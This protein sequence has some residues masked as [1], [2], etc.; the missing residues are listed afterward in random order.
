MY[1][2][3]DIPLINYGIVPGRV[4]GE[5][6]AVKGIFDLPKRIGETHHEW[7]ESDGVQPFVDAD[8]LFFNGR[9]ILFQGIIVG[10]RPTLKTLLNAFKNAVNAFTDVVPFETPYGTYC[11]LVNSVTPKFYNGGAVVIIE[12]TEPV[13]GATCSIG[14]TPT[15]YSSA[16][17][18][19]SATKNNCQSGYYGSSVTLTAT[20]GKFTSTISQTA[21]DLL[22]I[23]WVRDYKQDYANGSG[24]CIVN[25]PVW[26]N[27]KVSGV[28][29]KDDCGA[30][31]IGSEVSYEVPA[32][33]YSS[34]ISQA[35]ADAQAQAEFDT[36]LT[37]AYANSNGTCIVQFFN[38]F[39]KFERAKNDCQ[40]GYSGK[41]LSLS[42]PPGMVSSLISQA[43][44]NT[45]AMNQLM[46][47]LSQAYVNA[48]TYCVP[49]NPITLV[50][51]TK[52]VSGGR[53]KTWNIESPVI[54]GM[55][56]SF[57]AYGVLVVY[58]ATNF[59]TAATVASALKSLINAKSTASWNDA[60]MFPF[61]AV[62]PKATSSGSQLSV[63]LVYKKD[64]YFNLIA[65]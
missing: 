22:A 36:T 62:K 25:P 20:A 63:K 8:E 7:A 4:D 40:F 17:Y 60:D 32:F 21:A 52:P 65:I 61:Y 53:E 47:E 27:V 45:K 58:T 35:D 64:T 3:N 10:E 29:Q 37:Q 33:K 13:V 15:V 14:G 24:T 51:D 41:V 38:E 1:K 48:N 42:M 9:T 11:V 57:M 55:K 54:P 5:T 26:Y 16:E 56:F 23:Q 49:I 39:V 18:S 34:F 46:N 30:G 59:D 12:F 31:L 44:A 28:L 19:E 43:D 2:L 6:L 50:S